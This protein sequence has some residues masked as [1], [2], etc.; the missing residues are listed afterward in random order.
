VQPVHEEGE[1]GLA[2]DERRRRARLVLAGALRPEES[3]RRPGRR[4]MCFDADEMESSL[5]ERTDL[6]PHAD[7]PGLAARGEAGEL[8]VEGVQPVAVGLDRAAVVGDEHGADVDGDL[9]GWATGIVLT[10]A[11]RG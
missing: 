3:V 6:G 10:P 8:L 5:E 7:P 1:L 4:W 11:R 9:Q 2:A